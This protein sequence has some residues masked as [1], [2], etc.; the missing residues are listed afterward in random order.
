MAEGECPLPPVADCSRSS[1]PSSW[2]SSAWVLSFAPCSS[3]LYTKC[4]QRPPSVVASK[5]V[6]PPSELSPPF[7]RTLWCSFL[8]TYLPS[9][10]N[11]V[12]TMLLG[13]A[14]QYVAEKLNYWGE[15]RPSSQKTRPS[16]PSENHRTHSEHDNALIVKLFAF[17]LVNNYTS[18][19]YVA[20]IRPESHV[21]PA[22]LPR[23]NPLLQGFQHNGLFGL[24][25]EYRDICCDSTCGSLLAVQLFTHMLIKPLPKF[26]KDIIIPWAS[27]Y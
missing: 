20:F 10:L 6:A 19:F 13:Q 7:Q 23:S 21:P 16:S 17:Q 3:S 18:L 27:L 15:T 26:T 24:G 25:L 1:S 11:T 4:G 2:F 8:I 14:Y 22:L 5:W 9:I 12:S